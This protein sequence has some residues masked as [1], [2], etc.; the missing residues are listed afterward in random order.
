MVSDIPAGDRKIVNLFLQCMER[1]SLS[2]EG[3]TRLQR[4]KL[5]YRGGDSSTEGKTHLLIGRLVSGG[6]D[7]SKER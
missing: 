7:L 5:V 2:M 1:G 4:A 3:V 6:G